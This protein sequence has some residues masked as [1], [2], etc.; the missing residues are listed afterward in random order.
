MRRDAKSKERSNDIVN[1]RGYSTDQRIS[2]ESMNVNI[3][4]LEHQ[5]KESKLIGLSIQE[6]AIRGQILGAENRAALRCPEYD[7]NNIYWRRVDMLVQQQTD[8]VVMMNKYNSEMLIEN[9]GFGVIGTQPMISTFLNP[10]SPEQRRNESMAFD[11]SE[12]QNFDDNN[13]GDIEVLSDNDGNADESGSD[14]KGYKVK[15]EKI[16]RATKKAKAP[17]RVSERNKKKRSHR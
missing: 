5:K 16:K 2:I 1:T 8:C 4:R 6:S 15:V 3:R 7:P 14:D 13:V 10:L 9:D 17:T 12:V 11:I